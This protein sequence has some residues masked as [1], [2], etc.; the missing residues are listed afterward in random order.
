VCVYR[1]RPQQVV[2][3]IEVEQQHRQ[4]LGV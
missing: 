2:Q 3:E 1:Y 4:G